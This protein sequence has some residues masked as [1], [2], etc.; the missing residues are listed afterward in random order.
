MWFYLFKEKQSMENV[1]LKKTLVVFLVLLI[2]FPVLARQNDWENELI[3]S[4]NK[5]AGRATSYSY[6]TENEALSCNRDLSALKMLNVTWKFL[7]EPNSVN[8]SPDFFETDYDVSQWDDI[9]VPSCWEMRGYGT[10]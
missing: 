2:V 1:F 10:P 4:K 3:I 5:L 8:L 6:A 7:F 9:E